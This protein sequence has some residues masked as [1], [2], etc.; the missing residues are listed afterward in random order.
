MRKP[1]AV[2][3]LGAGK[4]AQSFIGR[5]SDLPGCLGPVK[6]FSY[7]V[8]SRIV[9]AIRAGHAVANL[10]EFD[11]CAITL[12]CVPESMIG[13]ALT[14]MCESAVNWR[15][16]TVVLCEAWQDASVLRPLAARGA[17]TAS[18]NAVPGFSERLF[19]ADGER[20]ALRDI[21]R[22]V[23]GAG[24]RVVR[25]NSSSKLLYMAGLTMAGLSGHVAAASSD[26]L[27]AAGLPVALTRPVVNALALD[28]VH[29]F[30][31]AGRKGLGPPITHSDR[32]AHAPAMVCAS[33]T[34]PEDCSSIRRTRLRPAGRGW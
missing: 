34:T 20:A 4:V 32:D 26:C 30:I 16:K 7:R 27:R 22:L 1:P 21:K 3:L 31:K 11:T 6:S 14:E 15:A 18:L 17:I 13:A 33:A 8:A 29:S 9:N 5:L 10:D 25:L 12:V 19:V 23:S 24:A 28:G 2:A